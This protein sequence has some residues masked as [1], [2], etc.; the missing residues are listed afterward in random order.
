MLTPRM[1]SA[2][3]AAIYSPATGLLVYQTDGVTP[4]F[5]YYNGTAWTALAGTSSGGG[6]SYMFATGFNLA[7][8]SVR[9][10]ALGG[11]FGPT[12]TGITGTPMTTACTF[13][14]LSIAVSP[15]TSGTATSYTV[16]LLVNGSPSSLTTSV[17]YSASPPVGVLTKAS[18]TSHTVSVGVGDIVTIEILPTVTTTTTA[19]VN[20][21]VHAH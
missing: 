12:T 16:T 11:N 8:A 10:I 19:F 2:Q 13:D 17:N 20:V 6:N 3:R 14:A 21:C 1:D 4:G 15:Q 7:T 18:D 9:Y 5:Y